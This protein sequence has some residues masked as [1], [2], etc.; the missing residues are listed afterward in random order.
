MKPDLSNPYVRALVLGLS[1][2]SATVPFSNAAILEKA[3]NSDNLNLTTSWTSGG[4]PGANDI[5]LWNSTVTGASSTLLGSD[6][7]WQ[8]L[9]VA[10]PGG[11]VAIG[12]G[13][14]LTLG[15]SGIDLGT[16]TQGLT[17]SSNLATA[18]GNQTWNVATGQ[19]LT[20]QTGTF[21][22]A[23]AATVVIDKTV[24]TGTITASNIVNTNNIVGPWMTVRSTGAAANGSASGNTF[25]TSGATLDAFTAATNSATYGYAT[26][27][28]AN[29][30]VNFSANQT[31]G[32]T[33]D[34]NTV[35]HIG[36]AA[37]I[38]TNSAQTWGFNG[39][40]NAGTGLLTL[41]D[42]GGQVMRIKAGVGTGTELVLHAANANISILDPIIN[43]GVNASSVTVNG[44]GTVTLGAAS[45]YTGG[46]TINSGTLSINQNIGA[47]NSNAVLNTGAT[48]A[49]TGGTNT[50]VMS[51]SGT[52]TSS[53]TTIAG[54]WSNFAGTLTHNN[55]TTSTVF[56]SATPANAS[57]TTSKFAAYTIASVQGSAQG[58]IAGYNTGS[59]TGTYT[60]ELGSLSGVANSLF[61]GGNVA[62]GIA[63][64]R[65][66]NLNTS[67]TFAGSFADG[68]NTKIALDKVGTGTLTL[69]GSSGNT[70]GTTVSSGTLLLTGALTSAANAVTVATGATLAGTGTIAGN[71]SVN[72][73]GL[74]VNGNGGGNALTLASLSFGGAATIQAT[75]NGTNPALAVTGALATTPANGQVA[76]NIA[77][78]VPLANGL[79]NI[80]S[81]GTFSGAASDFSA[82]VSSGINSRQSAS[83]VLDGNNIALQVIGDT[84][85]WTGAVDGNWT[86]N[87]IPGAKNW[88]LAAG[89]TPTD[90]MTGDNVLFDDTAT[91][92]TTLEL[93]TA[94][95]SAGIVEFNNSTKNYSISSGSGFTLAGGSLVKNGSGSLTLNTLNNSYT[96]GTTFNGGT[97]LLNADNALGSGTITMG[98]GSAKTLDAPVAAVAFFTDPAQ[99][100]NDNFTFTG[101]ND[102]DLGSGAVTIGGFDSDRTVTVSAGTL[103]TGEIKAPTHG[104]IKQGPGTLVVASNGAGAAASTV[105]GILDIAAGTLQIN[106]T[107]SIAA[108]SGDFTAAGLAGT[109]TIVNGASAERWLIVNTAA[110]SDFT[111]TLANG[112]AAG[113]GF[114]KQGV[115][116][117]TLSGALSYT[118]QTTV[119]GGTLT[120]PVANSGTGTNPVVNS[121]TLVM[122]HPA[123]FGAAATIRLAGNAVSTL[124]I[125]T[126]GGNNNY[127]IVFST[128]TN[129]TIVSNRA[130]A[131]PGINHTLSTFGINGI[132]GGTL[133]IASGANVTSGSGRITFTEF[134]LSAG[135]VQTTTFN[136]T[137]ANV[138]VG[139]VAKVANT[140]L[141]QTLGLGGTSDD[142]HVTGVISNGDGAAVVG[143]IK[144]NSSTWTISNTNT[145]T[146]NTQIGTLNGAGVLRAAASG[147]LGSGT[148][149]FDGSG[150]NPGPTSRLEL[151]NDITLANPVTLHQRNNTSAAILNVSGNNTLTGNIDL[152]V[153]GST[154]N[155]ASDAGL[156]TLTGNIATT[157]V[158]TR[159]LRL[160][161]AGNGLASGVISNGAGT[162]T[163]TKDGPGT[164]TLS[165]ANSYTGNTAVTGGTLSVA[166]AVL[167]DAATVNVDASAVLDLT[168]ASTDTVDRFFIGGVEQ[169]AGTWG[170][171]T[172]TATN[173]TARITGTGLLFATNGAAV[174]GYSGWATSFGLD[175]LTDGAAGVD[176]ELDGFDNGT[177]YILGGS[178]V[179]GSDNPKIYSLIADSSADGDTDPELVM[180]IAVPV[181]T[182]AFS[183]G[184]PTSATTFE[185]FGITVRGSTDLSAFPVTVT[186]V[187]PVVTGLPAAPVQGGIT[188]EYRSFSLGGSNGTT[189]KGF[190][191]VTVTN[192]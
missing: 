162:L 129:A 18:A 161:G 32:S 7:A 44:P 179:S 165:G 76:L 146:G 94:D 119:E 4:V 191:Q 65:I 24:G 75:Y 160:D 124:D 64:L 59:L 103:T 155:I 51:G 175:P 5:A 88:K 25:A 141:S 9:L 166:Q 112:G 48:L 37:I 139:N 36:G 26:S 89:N 164:W 170:S 41:G 157:T 120:I 111:G 185:G 130:T 98:T 140:A 21:T 133:T 128:T 171:L 39:L 153:G 27:T 169:V 70:A 46:T 134:G 137:T 192:P 74:L 15:R 142:N 43:N 116:S 127:G 13:N 56:N 187:D 10:N 115:G 101:T 106:R 12:A 92:S 11:P 28:T 183:A 50:N 181:G 109:G 71:V 176:K 113:L 114:L 178:P 104:L 186:P 14:T 168:H 173:K 189:G 177:E 180:T 60:L 68:T 154:G 29:Y 83:L 138:T 132:G 42:T 87:L 151:V 107:G 80:I 125:A 30:D 158:A 102:L 22:R 20:L 90:F 97:L 8:G 1:I 35:R 23:A 143:V 82:T 135:S 19:T 54:N 16:T 57:N 174:G 123:A 63:T 184:A 188:Y 55:T 34:A 149:V 172:S 62:Q 163:V 2:A 69:S 66:G 117:L 6:L 31:F 147:A 38:N 126:D 144:S 73:G 136:P 99:N 121:G 47:A 53:N 84:P 78:T 49:M 58:M 17:I 159:N 93:S 131:G 190:L 45:T 77:S 52:A 86:T 91:G 150:G 40:M 122:G 105:A 110:T 95:I 79:H 3:D 108:G 156:L 152:N 81:F 182:P 85:K 145:Y 72:S 96:G 167:A 61:R 148:I 67:T 100:W 118:G 33:R